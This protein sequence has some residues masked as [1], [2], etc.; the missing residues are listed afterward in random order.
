MKAKR[1]VVNGILF[2]VVLM[3]ALFLSSCEKYSQDKIPK[4]KSVLTEGAYTKEDLIYDYDYLWTVLDENYIFFPILKQN[5]VDIELLKEEARKTIMTQEPNLCGFMVNIDGMFQS[6]EH[7]GHLSV[8]DARGYEAYC[9]YY[10][11]GA[12]LGFFKDIL[13]DSRVITAYNILRSVQR[14]CL[15]ERERAGKVDISYVSNRNMIYLK[16]D[17][18]AHEF[19]D[20]D[21]RAILSFL[22]ELAKSENV[23]DHIVI[24]IT[25]NRGGD[26]NYW[27]R[28]IV[29]MFGGSYEWDVWNYYANTNITAAYLSEILDS[30]TL[31]IRP[32][33]IT[34]ISLSHDVP[35][36]VELL[37]LT[38][39]FKYRFEFSSE[40]DF[41]P[42]AK[43]WVLID[44][45]VYS[46]ADT[47]A[48]FCKATHWGTLVGERTG[49]D[50]I[51]VT[52]VLIK[53]PRT[54]L[55]VRF[56][57]TV[58]E[59]E[60]HEANVLM[61]TAPEYPCMHGEY[62]IDVLYRLL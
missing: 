25:G 42:D 20:Q 45:R 2:C 47:F 26:D 34:Q 43:R 62:P 57:V 52:P 56:S 9:R 48:H 46:S 22:E 4:S 15:S 41:F 27:D 18:F 54:G 12:G 37:E 16:I 6:L 19:I 49:G 29:S 31:D 23:V 58:A 28:N 38:H 61:G 21:Y 40:H 30:S 50:G 36:F 53:L 5:G 14:D 1:Y 59:T 3:V 60:A 11:E 33:P 32:S 8:L 13:Y 17:S 44:N 51:G 24:D 10:P 55:L 39:G 7:F 35:N